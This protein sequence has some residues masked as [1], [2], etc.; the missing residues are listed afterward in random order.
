MVNMPDAHL[1][2]PILDRL[3]RCFE[4]V[5]PNVNPSDIP[6]ATHESLAAWDSIAHVTLLSVIG[7][8]FG[9]DLDFEEFEGATSFAAILNLV[10]ARTVNA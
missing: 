6:A 3:I 8:E 5:F 2:Q 10:R 9:I 1:E 4:T 7:E